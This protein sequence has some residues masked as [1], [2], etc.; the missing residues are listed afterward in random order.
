M[1]NLFISILIINSLY[2]CTVQPPQHVN[3]GYKHEETTPG[4]IIFFDSTKTNDIKDGKWID[5]QFYAVYHCM[6]DGHKSE[7]YTPVDFGF[8][9]ELRI[10]I[11]SSLGSYAAGLYFDNHIELAYNYIML[12]SPTITLRH[13]FVHYFDDKMF[14]RVDFYHVSDNFR[15]CT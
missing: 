8:L 7:N 9:I 14:G 5:D 15:I 4:G 12:T 10:D 1:Y 2:G 6:I 11:V 3:Y 13:E